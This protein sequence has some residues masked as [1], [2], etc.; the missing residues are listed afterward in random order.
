MGAS[1]PGPEPRES[2][3]DEYPLVAAVKSIPKKDCIVGDPTRVTYY[4]RTG[5]EIKFISLLFQP[6]D[7]THLHTHTHIFH[8]VG[9]AFGACCK[10]V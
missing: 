6:E 5:D 4:R 1:K 10:F 2:S 7:M 8:T 9:I 3:V